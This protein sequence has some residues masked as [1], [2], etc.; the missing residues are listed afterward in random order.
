MTTNLLEPSTRKN[1]PQHIAIIMDGNGRWANSKYAY[2][3]AIVMALKTVLVKLQKL[4]PNFG[5]KY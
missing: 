5:I 4:Q 2:I 3:F 1:L